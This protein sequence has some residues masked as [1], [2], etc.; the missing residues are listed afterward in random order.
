[1]LATADTVG[2]SLIQPHLGI[3]MTRGRG[4][5]RLHFV[6][7]SMA[8]LRSVWNSQYFIFV[9]V[10]Y[11]LT[12]PDVKLAYGQGKLQAR[13]RDSLYRVCVLVIIGP[14]LSSSSSNM[15]GGMRRKLVN[16]AG[17]SLRSSIM[18]WSYI[19][20]SVAFRSMASPRSPSYVD[21]SP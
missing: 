18:S 16:D 19:P 8:T 6:R 11:G 5:E 2:A 1:M 9:F 10:N 14:T 3:Q 20:N 7:Y 4:P 12:N 17:S 13:Q 15:S 21:T